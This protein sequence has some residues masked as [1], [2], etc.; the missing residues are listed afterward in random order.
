[1][2]RS[3]PG[4]IHLVA[5]LHDVAH[6]DGFNLVGVKVR[7]RD[8]GSNRHRAESGSRNVLERASKGADFRPNRL[9]EDN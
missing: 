2:D 9:C 7:T 1:M 5:G 6:H 4:W 8:R 3:L